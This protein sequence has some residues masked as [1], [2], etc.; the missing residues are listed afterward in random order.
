MDLSQGDL[1]KYARKHNENGDDLGI[2]LGPGGAMKNTPGHRVKLLG[3]LR[4]VEQEY[5]LMGQGRT[6]ARINILVKVM[7]MSSRLLWE[8]SLQKARPGKEDYLHLNH[9][10]SL[11]MKKM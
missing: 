1:L 6:G 8:G 11:K 3:L 9:S 10:R 7:R 4:E 5:H 2:E